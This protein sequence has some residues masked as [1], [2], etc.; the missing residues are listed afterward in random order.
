MSTLMLPARAGSST[1]H[2]RD[3]RVQS[4]LARVVTLTPAPAID[5]VY[6]LG[7]VE[8]GHVNRASTVETYL[9]GNGINV[10]RALHLAGNPTLAVLP[11]NSED[12]KKARTANPAS[13]LS[14]RQLTIEAPTR[15]NAIAVDSN[16]V[17]TNF[18]ENAAPLSGSEWTRLCQLVARSIR[19]I[20][21][22]WLVLGGSIPLNGDTGGALDL[23][24]LVLAAQDAG[25]SVCFDTPGA[26]LKHWVETAGPLDLIK[27]NASELSSI[28]GMQLENLGDVV[29]AAEWLRE[30][31]VG[32]VLASLGP[33]GI[34]HVGKH[35]ALWARGPAARV[36]NTTGAGD[37]CLAGFLSAL[38]HGTRVPHSNDVL[39]SALGRAVSWGSLAVQQATTILPMVPVPSGVLVT[40]PDMARRLSA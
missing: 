18:N 23:N 7:Q 15:I 35:G 24:E 13:L 6:F 22:D 28:T 8:P 25:A 12:L 26:V 37:A 14:Y 32:T 20:K 27:P 40:E 3:V 17:T 29:A 10:S 11:I 36:L 21:S 38:P 34:I 2:S 5:R 16:G 19:E 33:D 4:P 9:A 39:R 31:G 1:S 30:R